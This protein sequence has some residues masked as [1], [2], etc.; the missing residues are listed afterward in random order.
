[1]WVWVRGGGEGVFCYGLVSGGSFVISHLEEGQVAW[2]FHSDQSLTI[3]GPVGLAVVAAGVLAAGGGS[4]QLLRAGR[5][6]A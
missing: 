4:P 3:H 6:R 1:M 2:F 5:M